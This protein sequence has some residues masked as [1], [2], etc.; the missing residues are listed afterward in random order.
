M[1]RISSGPFNI[2]VW[3]CSSAGTG[4]ERRQ[5][6]MKRAKGSGEQEHTSKGMRLLRT[7][8]KLHLM[9]WGWLRLGE[10]LPCKQGVSGSNPFHLHQQ[11]GFIPRSKAKRGTAAWPRGEAERKEQLVG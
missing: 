11:A 3:G 1:P 7:E 6:R 2:E 8:G 10:H 9:V 4:S 5:W